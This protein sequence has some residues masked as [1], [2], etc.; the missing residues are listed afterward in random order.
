MSSLTLSFPEPDLAVLTFCD[1]HRGANVLSR[2]VLA[3]LA[4]QLDTLAARPDLVGLIVTSS[5]PGIFLAGADIRELAASFEKPQA[6]VE[7]YC[8]DGRR[9]FQRLGQLPYPSVVAFEGLALGGGLELMLW[10]DFRVAGETSRTE[11]GCPEV[12]LGLIPGWGGLWTTTKLAGLGNA[13]E[14]VCAGENIPAQK[15]RSLGVI[16]DVVPAGKSLDAA[17]AL[18]R[19]PHVAERMRE[20]RAKLT[21][22][23][24]MSE[25]ET[26]FLASTARI[27]RP[28][29]RRALSCAAQGAR[30]ADRRLAADVGRGQRSRRARNGGAGRH[31]GQS[32]ADRTLLRASGTRKT[33]E[34]MRRTHDSR[35]ARSKTSGSSAR[36]SWAIR[37]RRSI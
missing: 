14:I 18:L 32:R 13:V 27:Y 8:R 31:A 6:E 29:N 3:E 12:K 10:A 5:K 11:V 28:P 9:L 25:I 24:A 19:D 36:G 35:R 17:I 2:A 22:P 4:A 26:E 21:A 23:A 37:S 7:A 1:P 30:R 16:D 15:A 34:S 20:R 33:V